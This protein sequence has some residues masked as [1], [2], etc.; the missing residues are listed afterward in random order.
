[1][2][3]YFEE[4]WNQGN[5]AAIDEF[6][7][8]DFIGH[9]PRADTKGPEAEKEYVA[10]LR[11][12]FPDIHIRIDDQIAE[13]DKVVTRW[14]ARAT[15]TGAFQGIPATG[16]QGA[17]TGITIDRIA[18]GKFVEGWAIFDELGLMQQIGVIPATEPA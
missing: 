4:V 1:V 9:H 11:E 15:H 6:V 14:T 5:L 13:G 7:S 17:V 3:R 18:N 10:M 8:S 12:A 16:K 2:F